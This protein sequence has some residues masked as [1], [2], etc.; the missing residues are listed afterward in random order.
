[1]KQVITGRSSNQIHADHME[2]AMYIVESW[3]DSK[4]FT[5]DQ[6]ESLIAAII[7][8]DDYVNN[9]K[10]GTFYETIE[11]TIY[12]ISEKWFNEKCRYYNYDFLAK[13]YYLK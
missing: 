12:R 9:L 7:D 8:Y 3:K 4:L 10:P 11:H 5:D 13:K 1:M 6:I 2:L